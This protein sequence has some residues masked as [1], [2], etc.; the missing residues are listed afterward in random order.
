MN[1]AVDAP[2]TLWS[3]CGDVLWIRK[4]LAATRSKARYMAWRGRGPV[5]VS[6][7]EDLEL[8]AIRVTAGWLRDTSTG[9]WDEW[10]WHPCESTDD[11]AV[12]Y[13]QVT[14]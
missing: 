7:A 3:E 9:A 8:T 10:P 4:D 1:V 14:A 2:L 12:A 13:W 5:E 11:G 6:F